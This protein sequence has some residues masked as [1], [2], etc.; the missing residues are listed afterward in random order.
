MA[1]NLVSYQRFTT[2]PPN[3]AQYGTTVEELQLQR[4]QPDPN[5]VLSPM[6]EQRVAAARLA[7]SPAGSDRSRLAMP[8]EP[9]PNPYEGPRSNLVL[10][11]SAHDKLTSA[12]PAAL[13]SAIDA[14]DVASD[15]KSLM[16]DSVR[17]AFVGLGEY[18]GDNI[19]LTAGIYAKCIASSKG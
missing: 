5:P 18:L 7:L 12:L 14:A 16:K 11:R 4:G 1:N 8:A 9:D 19:K 17:R 13:Q 10:T 3:I 15:T 6:P 2:L